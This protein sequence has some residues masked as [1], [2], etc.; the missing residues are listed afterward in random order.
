MLEEWSLSANSKL[1]RD[2]NMYKG[3]EYKMLDFWN[4]LVFSLSIFRLQQRNRNYINAFQ[5]GETWARLPEQWVSQD[6]FTDPRSFWTC[7]LMW[8]LQLALV[9]E[10]LL[11]ARPSWFYSGTGT[12]AVI[13]ASCWKVMWLCPFYMYLLSLDC[14][15]DSLSLQQSICAFGT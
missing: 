11:P 5:A 2:I 10:G 14:C 7:L 4:D 15:R 6:P 8:T 13:Y 9:L 1:L 12:G 3:T